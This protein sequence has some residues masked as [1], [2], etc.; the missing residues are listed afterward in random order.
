MYTT[1]SSISSAEI[2]NQNTLI[3]T[4]NKNTVFEGGQISFE[5]GYFG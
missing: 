2:K 5:T 4:I 1:Y 3:F